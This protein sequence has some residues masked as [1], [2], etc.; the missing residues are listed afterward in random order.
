MKKLLAFVLILALCLSLCTGL[1]ACVQ[2]ETGSSTTST[3]SGLDAA[4]MYVKTLYKETTEKTSRDFTRIGSVP[5]NGK[6][7]EV[8]WSVD[9]AEEFVKVVKNADGTVTIDVNETSPEEV[10][11]TLPATIKDGDKVVS[12]SWKHIVPKVNLD[13]GAIVD[14]AYAL[15][16]GASMDYEVTLTGVINKVDTPYDDGYKNVTVTMDV[17][18][19]E[20]KPIQCYRLKGEGAE[21]L[22][23]GDTITVS[24]ILTNYQ[25]KIQFQAGCVLL[26][27]TSAGEVEAPTDV[28]T[29]MK[30]AFELPEGGS[31][32]YQATLTG[33]ITKINTPYN[34]SFKNVSVTIEIEGYEGKELLCYRVKGEGADSLLIGDTITVK[35]YIVNYKGGVQFGEGSSLLKV[36]KTGSEVKAPSDPKQIVKEAYALKEDETLPYKATLTGKITKVNEYYNPSF[37]NIT[38]TIV[39]AGMNDKPIKVYRLAGKG[40]ENEA[41][42]EGDTI[43]VTGMITNYKGEVEFAQGCTLDKWENTNTAAATYETLT[44]KQAIDM[45]LAS[46]HDVYSDKK[47]QVTGVI[48]EVYNTQYGNMKITDGNGNILTLYGTY[49]KDGKDRYDAMS[50]KPDA[51]DTVTVLGVVG[52][53]T[54]TPQIKNGW[55]LSFKEGE[56]PKVPSAEELGIPAEDGAEIT[57][58]QAN[59][60]GEKIPHNMFTETKYKVTGVIKEVYNADYGNMYIVD[61]E[62]NQLTVYGTFNADGSVSYKDMAVKPIAGDTITVYGILGQYNGTAQIKNGWIVA[63]TPYTGDKYEVTFDLNYETDAE[64][65]AKREVPVDGTYGTLPTPEREGYNFDGWYLTE[66]CDGEAVE[67]TTVVTKSHTLYAKWTEKPAAPQTGLVAGK[68]YIFGMTQGNL[69]N[70]VYYLAGGMDGYYMATTLDAAAAVEVYVEE[71]AGGYYF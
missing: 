20:G 39:V 40:V 11:Y 47:Y 57:I 14:E 63:H 8:V 10:H 43:T 51:G 50:S 46:E 29:I 5:V 6:T 52:N 13:F 1:T 58:K 71:T 16:Q 59:A 3:Q 61:A 34:P 69:E 65:P 15:E 4:L 19:I 49:S 36:E 48:T 67:A 45:A 12:Y 24:G 44:V 32:Q 62:G 2:K 64:A 41:F 31:T 23:P 9:V 33:K 60:A 42:G 17:V 30:E 18:G 22:K 66:A 53:Y 35:G 28:A 70:K 21:N 37:G 25:G 7:Y 26:S 55:I 68:P 56:A 27:V 54:G 38:V